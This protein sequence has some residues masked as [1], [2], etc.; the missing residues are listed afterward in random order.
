MSKKSNIYIVILLILSIFIGFGTTQAY[1]THRRGLLNTFRVGYNEITVTE[2][3]NPPDEIVPGETIEFRKNVRVKNTGTVPCFVRVRLEYSDSE[4]KSF[5]KNILYGESID[6]NDWKTEIE[7]I[8]NGDWVYNETDG[9]Y[10]YT[11][12]LE[13]DD[14]TSLLLDKVQV[15]VPKSEENSLKDF[16]IYVYAESI[17]TM[18]TTVKDNGDI[19][20]EEAVDYR[21]AWDSMQN[22]RK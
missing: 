22:E 9:C 20:S 17:Q 5:C 21:D 1:F 19:I 10:Y 14:V 3:Y 16:E 12:V 7:R 15:L 2:D 11:K 4:M 18:I 8:S 6:A 13:E